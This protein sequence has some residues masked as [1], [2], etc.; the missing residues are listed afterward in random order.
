MN[1]Y[2]FRSDDLGAEF[3]DEAR[4][5]LSYDMLSAEYGPFVFARTDN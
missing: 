4:F 1:A 2:T 3:S 5:R